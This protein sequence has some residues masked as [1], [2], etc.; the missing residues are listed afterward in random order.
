MTKRMAGS[1]AAVALLFDLRKEFPLQDKEIIH[2]S[3]L[4]LNAL[5]LPGISMLLASVPRFQSV[6]A[7]A[8]LSAL[9]GIAVRM[10]ILLCY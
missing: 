9:V 8:I 4:L 7:A 3:A 2:S 5:D 1:S 6:A 10:A